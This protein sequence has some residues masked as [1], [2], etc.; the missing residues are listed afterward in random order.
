MAR[1]RSVTH[2][3]RSVAVAL[4]ALLAVDGQANAQCVLP[5][6][7]TTFVDGEGLLLKAWTF[8]LAPVHTQHVMPDDAAFAAY[9]AQLV[10]EGAYV[11]RPALFLPPVVDSLQLEILQDELANN[12]LVYEHGVGAIEPVTCLDALLYA[13]HNARVPQLER[14]TEFI[15][16]VLRRAGPAG[17]EVAV[18]FGAG[19][20]TFPPSRVHG[21]DVVDRY[22]A[23]GW[24]YWYLLHNHTRQA[25]GDLGVPAPS[26]SD[27]RFVRA[28]AAHRGLQRVRV[29]NGFHTFDAAVDDIA[30]L[31]ER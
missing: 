21:F 8:P 11:E 23:E 19:S 12:S 16:S 2:A 18:L 6:D 25:N 10:A 7:G 31:R 15:A 5:A 1:P 4:L 14:Q 3:L 27:V 24:T 26:T 30:P 17:D 29:T 22:V 13:F 9:R 28:L 20:G